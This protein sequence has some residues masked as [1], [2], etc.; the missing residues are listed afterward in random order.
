MSFDTKPMRFGPFFIPEGN[1]P[2]EGAED[3][4]DLEECERLKKEGE[5]LT[6][7]NLVEREK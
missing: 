6:H 7:R 3:G 2:A 4:A 1:N 5:I